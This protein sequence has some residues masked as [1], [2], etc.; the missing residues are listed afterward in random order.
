MS[1]YHSLAKQKRRLSLL[2][3]LSIF[4]III[5]LGVGFLSFKY[6]NYERQELLRLSIQSQSIVKTIQENPL[7]QREI[8]EGK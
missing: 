6:F 5:F 8:L 7:I 1:S 2:F 3:S 4:S